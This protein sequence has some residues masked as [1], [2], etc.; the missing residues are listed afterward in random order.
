VAEYRGSYNVTDHRWFDLRDADTASPN[1]QQHYGLMHD[2][3]TPKP[4]YAS[5]KR[6]IGELT[7]KSPPATGPPGTGP[8]PQPSVKPPKPRLRLVVRCYRRGVRA[9]VRGSGVRR[10]A[11]VTFRARGTS[12]TDGRRPFRRSVRLRKQR[13]VRVV[14]LARLREGGELRLVRRSPA[15]KRATSR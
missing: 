4:A 10:V 5:W 2:D 1:F 6:L 3:Y 8:G 9:W 11:S 14:A 13:R 12:V 15:C 7:V